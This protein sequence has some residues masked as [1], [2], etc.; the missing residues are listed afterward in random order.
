[1]QAIGTSTG[2]DL[3]LTGDDVGTAAG[4]AVRAC[5]VV[6][7][8][9]IDRLAAELFR[10]HLELGGEHRQLDDLA[11][12]GAELLGDQLVEAPLDRAARCPRSPSG[13]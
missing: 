3:N 4:V 1:M 6:T 9:A 2:S 8:R 11:V 5:A 13:P 10:R 12:R 7:T